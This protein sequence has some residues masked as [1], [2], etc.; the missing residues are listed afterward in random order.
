MV[1]IKAS[2]MT[3]VSTCAVPERPNLRIM[4]H[5]DYRYTS[6]N[7]FI[8]KALLLIMSLIVSTSA[9]SI[10]QAP[11]RQSIASDRGYSYTP[12]GGHIVKMRN[13][14]LFSSTQENDDLHTETQIEAMRN[15][16]MTISKVKDDEKRRRTIVALIKEKV[17]VDDP[18]EGALFVQLW[19][20]TLIEVGG[21]FQN[22]AREKA[23]RKAPETKSSNGDEGGAVGKT[24]QKSDDELQLWALVD[25][26]IQSKTLIK[27]A[28]DL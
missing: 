8:W 25:M 4:K 11:S 7:A 22:E 19:D 1:L 16:I 27:K 17:Q 13:S 3:K 26:M 14:G 12:S 28:M 20:K 18:M 24:V 10:S 23:T 21:Q 9:F 15:R 6:R 2:T 5:F